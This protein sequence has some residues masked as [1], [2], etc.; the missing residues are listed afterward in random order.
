MKLLIITPF[1]YPH[2]GGMERSIYNL[3]KGL[4]HNNIE[5]SIYTTI[6]GG[7]ITQDLGHKIYQHPDL[8]LSSWAEGILEYIL[9]HRSLDFC[10][11]GGLGIDIM[12]GLIPVFNYLHNVGVKT[13]L[14]IPTSDHIQRHLGVDIFPEFLKKIDHF[15][16]IDNLAVTY[17]QNFAFPSQI[18][19]V[20]NGVDLELFSN[21]KEWAQR[22][23][24]ILYRGRLSKRKNIDL[25]LD[26]AEILQDEFQFILQGSESFGESEYYRRIMG[27]AIALRNVEIIPE[28]WH[29]ISTYNDAK[30]F[31]LPSQSEGCPNSLLEA[32]ACELFCISSDIP[33]NKTIIQSYGAYFKQDSHEMADLLRRSTSDP[34]TADL[35]RSG[36]EYI[37]NNFSINTTINKWL[38]IIKS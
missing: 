9:S 19:Y 28:S 35:V 34:K 36:K 13:A 15:V 11:F 16:C 3:A 18:H 22:K 29:D 32:M 21:K 8:S 6:F 24:K 12:N 30:Y 26:T 31:V 4:T 33:E 38:D 1:Y 25:I 37:R 7:E 27:R 20:P 2:I 10:I 14:R 5:V 23:N 17:V